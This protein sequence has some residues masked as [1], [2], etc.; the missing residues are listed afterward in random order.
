MPQL[1][2][3]HNDLLDPPPNIDFSDLD[4][5]MAPDGKSV[6]MV[7]DASEEDEKLDFGDSD[8][9]DDPRLRRVM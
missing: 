7:V 4:E 6:K 9:R 2:K 5:A 3:P 8:D 1:I